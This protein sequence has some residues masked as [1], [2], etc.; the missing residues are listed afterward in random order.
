MKIAIINSA[1]KHGVSEYSIRSCL[2]NLK[3][4]IALDEEPEKRLFVG[5][6]ESGNP[7]ELVGVIEVIR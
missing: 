4:D 3:S 6:D 5:F 1:Y 2:L 7:L